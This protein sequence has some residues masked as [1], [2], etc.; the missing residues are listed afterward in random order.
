MMRCCG[1]SSDCDMMLYE[2]AGLLYNISETII[3][4]PPM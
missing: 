2:T 4:H 1:A 3:I